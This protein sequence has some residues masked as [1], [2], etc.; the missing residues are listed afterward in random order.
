LTADEAPKSS[1]DAFSAINGT[2]RDSLRWIGLD[3]LPGVRPRYRDYAD[4]LDSNRSGRRAWP[5]RSRDHW[6]P[7]SSALNDDSPVDGRSSSA[8]AGNPLSRLPEGRPVLIAGG[9]ADKAALA[10]AELYQP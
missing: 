10:S 3:E 9:I 7:H 1:G 4:A 5:S 6:Q 8:S 2:R